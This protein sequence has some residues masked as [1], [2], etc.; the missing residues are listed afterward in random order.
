MVDKAKLDQM[1]SN[2]RSYTQVL[3]ALAALPRDAFLANPDKVGNAK[4]HLVIAI[5]CCIDIA[6]HIIASENYRF[7][8]DNADSFAVLI[9]EG[10]L[11]AAMK[12]ALTAMARFRNRLV[13]LYWN[14]DD[15]R[16][17]EYLQTSLGDVERFSVSVAARD[18]KD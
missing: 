1:L 11:D 3:N 7:P 8:K 12:D 13:H 18:W 16:V 15:S 9:E 5:E 10:I 6:N 4:Y 2:L 17:H 14:V